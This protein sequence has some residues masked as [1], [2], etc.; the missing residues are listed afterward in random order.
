MSKAQERG[1]E[2]AQEL[3]EALNNEF[4]SNTAYRA[5]LEEAIGTLQINLDALDS[6]EDEELEEED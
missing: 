1:E 4:P 5:A 3:E 2:L 6:G